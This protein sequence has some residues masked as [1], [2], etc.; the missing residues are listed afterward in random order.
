[1]GEH[2]NQAQRKKEWEL[3]CD[4]IFAALDDLEHF[5]RLT[6]ALIVNE[7]SVSAETL[8]KTNEKLVE[9]FRDVEG[10]MTDAEFNLKMNEIEDFIYEP[11]LKLIK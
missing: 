11:R 6:K 5:A 2:M 10:L 4:K 9:L 1:M 8:N 3:A 7:E